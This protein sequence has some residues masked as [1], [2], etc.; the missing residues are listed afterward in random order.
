MDWTELLFACRSHV[1]FLRLQHVGQLGSLPFVRDDARNYS[2][3]DHS[4]GVGAIAALITKRYGMRGTMLGVAFELGASFHDIGHCAYSHCFDQYLD[5]IKL[6]PDQYPRHESRSAHILTLIVRDTVA[7]GPC[8]Q[9]VHEHVEDFIAIAY[10]FITPTD[11][12]RHS[13]WNPFVNLLNGQTTRH[14]D[15][16]RL[17]YIPRDVH[18]LRS[19][20]TEE[21]IKSHSVSA[22]LDELVF[23]KEC[24]KYAFS[25][26]LSTLLLDT[27]ETLV[28]TVYSRPKAYDWIMYSCFYSLRLHESCN[29]WDDYSR[30]MF[31]FAI[32]S[33][34][35]LAKW[36]REHMAPLCLARTK[37]M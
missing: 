4:M 32:D 23:N 17:E 18:L 2:R 14:L 7:H 10:N 6:H 36:I 30:N 9:E 21:E 1:L 5:K 11:Y 8:S 19:P 26:V 24:N 29:I 13:T 15:I 28:K 20:K 37:H 3:W 33:N 16:D 12:S 22:Y 35:G 27:R 34:I 25:G 31:L